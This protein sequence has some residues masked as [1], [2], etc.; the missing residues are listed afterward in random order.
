MICDSRGCPLSAFAID[1]I[2]KIPEVQSANPG[3]TPSGIAKKIAMKGY[4]IAMRYEMISVLIWHEKA[5][6]VDCLRAGRR[7]IELDRSLGGP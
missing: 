3:M 6:N 1:S 7:E 5:I 2:K 4:Q